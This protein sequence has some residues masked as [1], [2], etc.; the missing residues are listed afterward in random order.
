MALAPLLVFAASEERSSLFLILPDIHELI[1]GIVS[2][3]VLVFLIWKF[4]GPA[5]AATLEARQQAVVQDL[6]D[7]EASKEQAESLLEDYRKQLADAKEE[8]NRIIESARET[9]ESLKAELVSK[10]EAEAEQIVAKARSEV[11]AE[12]ERAL[13]E[14]RQE[15]ADMSLDLAERVVQESIDRDSQRQLIERYLNDLERMS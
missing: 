14:V 1:W 6:R 4:A 8:A 10:A 13:A 12:R 7:A 9:A 15:V 11:A 5:L 2:F 3:A